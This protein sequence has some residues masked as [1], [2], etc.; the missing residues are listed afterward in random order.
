MNGIY[1]D[2]GSRTESMTG[3]DFRKQKSFLKRLT[4]LEQHIGLELS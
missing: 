1:M 2:L 4:C 3:L